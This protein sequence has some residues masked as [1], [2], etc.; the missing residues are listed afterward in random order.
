MAGYACSR[1]SR[2]PELPVNLGAYRNSFSI[3]IHR[4]TTG[5]YRMIS[6]QRIYPHDTNDYET[7]SIARIRG[8]ECIPGLG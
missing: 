6:L 5:I 8:K 7:H 1:E 4:Q 3:S 2:V